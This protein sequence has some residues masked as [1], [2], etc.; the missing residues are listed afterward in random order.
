MGFFDTGGVPAQAFANNFLQTL[1]SGQKH[2][3]EREKL[4]LA[5]QQAQEQA[6]LQAA[7]IKAYEAMAAENQAQASAR[8]RAEQQQT[9]FQTG[10]ADLIKPRETY[11]MMGEN[12]VGG[13]TMAD[14]DMNPPRMVPGQPTLE[15]RMNLYRQFA[16]PQQAMQADVSMQ[17][18]EA[19]TV[20]REKINE[21]RNKMLVQRTLDQL[22]S[23][24]TRWR[25]RDD[26]RSQA[27]ADKFEAKITE[28]EKIYGL[29]RELQDAKKD[30]D[31]APTDKDKL[32]DSYLEQIK[33]RG[34]KPMSRYQFDIWMAKQK[35]D[36]LQDLIDSLKL[37]GAQTPATTT[38][39]PLSYFGR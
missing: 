36:R 3:L 4:L 8:Q 37:G 26:A 20:S 28:I 2:R 22:A 18:V 25:E 14:L 19:N 12:V 10:Y 13:D 33:E 35:P 5:Q 7:H 29:K 39:K 16:T 1:E 23:Q 6:K 15:Q 21:E 9:A 31:R 34:E 38:R 30:K 11:G 24:E 17:N 27:M 32:Y